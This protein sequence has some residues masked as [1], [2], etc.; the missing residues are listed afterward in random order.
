MNKANLFSD[1]KTFYITIGLCITFHSILAQSTNTEYFM[2]TSFAKTSINPAKRPESGYIGIPG[3][4]N[5]SVDFKTNTLN[6]NHFLFPGVGENGKT[7]LFLN[8]NVSYN[9][10]MKN[11]SS[12]NYL[13]LNMNATLL[14]CGWFYTNDLFLS[15]DLSTRVNAGVNIPKD[16]F[17]FAKKG[18]STDKDGE[19]YDLSDLKTNVNAFT[20]IGFGGSY[21]IMD[22]SLVV[23]SKLKIL[24]GHA[25]ADLQI[26]DLRIDINNDLWTVTTQASGNI[27]APKLQVGYSQTGSLNHLDFGGSFSLFN[28]WGLG[29]DLGATFKPGDYFNFTDELDWLYPLTISAALTDIGFIS[30]NTS[31]MTSFATNPTEIIVT[32]DHTISIDEPTDF[33]KEIKNTVH[34]IIAFYPVNYPGI[35][36]GLG[37]RLNWGLEY[38]FMDDQMNAGFLNT[39]YFNPAKT[40]SEFTIAG[41]YRPANV[42]ELGLSYSFVHSSF[43]TIGFALHLGPGFYIASDYIIPYVNSSFL[44]TSSKA[45]NIQLGGVIPIGNK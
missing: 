34:D 44:P 6:L 23:G 4:T 28:G 13:G 16:F 10:F 27:L 45:L 15:F 2:S 7:G 3:L 36:S 26:E 5:I 37:C 25:Y 40:I 35:I 39:V 1:I 21:L 30:W 20:Q 14:G 17:D 43:Q 33:F 9:D 11:I 12:K 22:R 42:V 41:A 32:G 38:A 31:K 18:L 29:L 24:L 8:E 19:T